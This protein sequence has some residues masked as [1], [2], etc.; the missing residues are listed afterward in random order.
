MTV[1][2]AIIYLLSGNFLANGI[3]HIL[4]GLLGKKFIKCPKTVSQKSFER[5]YAGRWFSS[6]VFN[7]FY[8]LVQIYVVFTL[9]ILFSFHPAITLET[10]MLA[11]GFAVGAMLL[12]W[13]YEG[14]LS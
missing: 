10:G 9:G 11:T 1:L 6:A 13:K 2:I 5:V 8:G 7:C 14:T 3:F 4:M 12:C